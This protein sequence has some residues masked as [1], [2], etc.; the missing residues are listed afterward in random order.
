MEEGRALYKYSA[1]AT[2]LAYVTQDGRLVIWNNASEIHQQYS[3]SSHLSTQI[4]CLAWSPASA[5]NTDKKNKKNENKG[6]SSSSDLIALGTSAG[7]LLVYSVKQGDIVTTFDV[8]NHKVM[9]L[10]WSNSG[11]SVVCATERGEITICCVLSLQVLSRFKPGKTAINALALT[12]DDKKIVAASQKL[13]VYD[14][15]TQSLVQTFAGHS[16]L[17]NSLCCVQN[18]ENEAFVLSAAAEDRN[19]SVWK[20]GGETATPKKA[21]PVFMTLSV[22]DEIKDVSCINI[23]GGDVLACAS[24]ESGKAA[25]FRT[26]LEK[27][28]KKPKKSFSLIHIMYEEEEKIKDIPVLATQFVNRDTLYINISYGS[29]IKL[30]LEE[31]KISELRES[32]IL[33]REMPSLKLKPDT[34]K[35]FS[36]D[37]RMK[38]S[39]DVKYLMARSTVDSNH[40]AQKGQKR[41]IGN[42]KKAP[43]TPASEISLVERL[44]TAQLGAPRTNSYAKLLLQGLQSKNIAI[45]KSVTHNTDMQVIDATCRHLPVESI[46]PFLGHLHEFILWKIHEISH[47]I[48]AQAVIRHHIG[49][50]VSSPKVHSELLLPLSDLISAR[51]SNFLPI[52]KLKGKIEMIQRQMDHN[53][54]KRLDVVQ[55][56]LLAYQDESD[57]EEDG[58][59]AD[60]NPPPRMDYDSDFLDEYLSDKDEQEDQ[61]SDEVEEDDDEMETDGATIMTNGHGKGNGSE[62]EMVE[63]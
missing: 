8:S 5:S 62:D 19:V 36:K 54:N 51:T 15:H 52:L 18:Q 14:V 42:D 55:A 34:Q 24:T 2:R 6:A 35:S 61:S 46:V 3:P 10:T 9:C 21:D 28:R 7:S 43:P 27:P 57:E 38:D 47:V 58:G 4:T 59:E 23:E 33:A 1:D 44:A 17:V 63:D 31:L 22:N 30:K 26:S 48:W 40:V 13:N 49:Y 50:L 60:S 37:V 29:E 11:R 39:E 41:S 12:N 32:H 45:I 56:P 16:N 20:L 53:R 25:I